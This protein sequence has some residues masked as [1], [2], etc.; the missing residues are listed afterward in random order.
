MGQSFNPQGIINAF[1]VLVRPKLIVPHSVVKDIRDI[2]Y[3]KLKEGGIKT[4]AFDKDNCLTAPYANQLHA[5]FKESWT[6]CKRVFGENIVIVSNSAGTNDDAQYKKV[7]YSYVLY[8]FRVKVLRREEKKPGGGGAL[9]KYCQTTDP[10]TIAFVGD[11]LLTDVLFGNL[12]GMYTIFTK[13]I[14]TEQGDNPIALKVLSTNIKNPSDFLL[15]CVD[16]FVGWNTVYW[17]GF[18]QEA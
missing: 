2:N 8:M 3:L 10:T 13:Q 15:R 12:N 5:P 6:E 1:K 4:I 16:S 11:R 14:V 17:S 7:C 9:L 18:K